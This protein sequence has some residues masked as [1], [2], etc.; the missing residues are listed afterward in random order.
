MSLRRR[1]LWDVQPEPDSVMTAAVLWGGARGGRAPSLHKRTD[2]HTHT[3][4]RA[5]AI[6]VQVQG[7]QLFLGAE[8]GG[9]GHTQRERERERERES[10]PHL[11]TAGERH[12]D[13]GGRGISHDYG[14]ASCES[15]GPW[16]LTLEGRVPLTPF[17]GS[18]LAFLPRLAAFSTEF[19]ARHISS[20]PHQLI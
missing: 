8:P 17:P 2:T 20:L 14:C 19:P 1:F 9:R 3:H 5:R 10:L 18:I 7:T 4:T 16:S 12:A 11:R 15:R 13:P 6:W